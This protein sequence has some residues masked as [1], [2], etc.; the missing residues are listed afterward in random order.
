[1][2]TTRDAH[3]RQPPTPMQKANAETLYRGLI[4]RAEVPAGLNSTPHRT[5][6]ANTAQPA[7]H[8][9]CS[10]PV[11][12]TAQSRA[13]TLARLP[14]ALRLGM[15]PK[16]A[17]SSMMARP[18]YIRLDRS[19]SMW[20]SC[21]CPPP[22]ATQAT[23]KHPSPRRTAQGPMAH[24]AAPQ[25]LCRP[26]SGRHRSKTYGTVRVGRQCKRILQSA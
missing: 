23:P 26:R 16:R 24:A 6:K 7:A 18:T 22:A 5:H 19:S 1:M 3:D 11:H 17:C 21:T 10:T 2:H 25:V 12:T 13:A 14:F 4:T 8:A 15:T 20:H 9:A